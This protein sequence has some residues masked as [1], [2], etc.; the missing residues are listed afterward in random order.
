LELQ[1]RACLHRPGGSW[2]AKT[3]LGRGQGMS[4]FKLVGAAEHCPVEQDSRLGSN[5]SGCAT[6]AGVPGAKNMATGRSATPG[7]AKLQRHQGRVVQ[8]AGKTSINPRNW[9]HPVDID[10]GDEGSGWVEQAL[11]QASRARGWGGKKNAQFTAGSTPDDCRA[12]SCAQSSLGTSSIRTCMGTIWLGSVVGGLGMEKLERPNS[13]GVAL[14][15][16][17]PEVAGGPTN[18][19]ANG[20]NEKAVRGRRVP[21]VSR[22]TLRVEFQVEALA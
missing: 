19:S 1:D 4:V 11:D 13:Q 21:F 5:R 2:P 15:W 9:E 14:G 6:L 10:C 18:L 16:G 3:V 12:L 22:S 7:P 17:P 20:D 8:Q